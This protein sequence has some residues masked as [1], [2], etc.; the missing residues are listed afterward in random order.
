MKSLLFPV[1]LFLFIGL[2]NANEA[3][4]QGSVWYLPAELGVGPAIY[5]LIPPFGYA[6]AE[7]QCCVQSIVDA[8]DYCITDFWDLTC[9]NA[10]ENCKNGCGNESACNYTSDAQCDMFF[11]NCYYEERW[12]LPPHGEVDVLYFGCDPPE[13]YILSYDDSC[14][15][16]I[17]DI[18]SSCSTEGWNS[19]CNDAYLSCLNGCSDVN[20][21]NYSLFANSADHC[22]YPSWYIPEFGS[23]QTPL[24]ACDQPEGY[25][26]SDERCFN[27][28]VSSP[29]YDEPWAGYC[30]ENYLRC[31]EY[32]GCTD[33][34]AC[35]YSPYA[36]LDDG[37]CNGIKGCTNISANNFNSNANCDD[38]SCL[39]VASCPGDF[40]GDG[41]IT[42][43]DL[44]GFLGVF[45][46]ECD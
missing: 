33:S 35:N 6:E 34:E 1:I 19:W 14:V 32:Y 36:S 40:N 2:F 27:A 8:D 31:K 26:P 4:A 43:T 22:G 38:G 24:L 12:F 44:T 39:V 3:H 5:G 11:F 25:Y 20:S 15:S 10:Y 21:C 28:N 46:L 16:H 9:Y 18:D 7:D 23:T 30:V 17:V 29:C 41:S 42:T 13:G 37:T 45:G